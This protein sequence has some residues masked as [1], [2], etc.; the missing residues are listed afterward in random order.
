MEPKQKQYPVVHVNS[1][2]SKVW[3]CKEQ[4][5]IGACNVRSMNQGKLDVVKQDMARVNVDIL[6]ISEL[7]WTARVNLTQMTIIRRQGSRS[8][9]WKRN[10]KSQNGCLRRPYKQLWKEEKWKTKEKRKDIPIWAEIQR[11]A[12]RDK[13]AFLTDQGKK[14]EENNRMGKTRDHFKKNR[15]TKGTFHEKMGSMKDTEYCR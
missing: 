13:K 15:D 11:I 12:R 6:G 4:Y 2:R 7:K 14:I 3:C 5:C 1:D 8:S 9:I 10:A